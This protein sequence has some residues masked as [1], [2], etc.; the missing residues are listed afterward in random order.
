MDHATRSVTIGPGYDDPIVIGR[1]VIRWRWA[2]EFRNRH[3]ALN[4][5]RTLF[6][7]W[8]A[9]S[10]QCRRGLT[11]ESA[12]IRSARERVPYNPVGVQIIEHRWRVLTT[13]PNKRHGWTPD[14]QSLEVG[15]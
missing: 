5:G 3:F 14:G 12:A 2:I 6:L 13:M 9:T 8:I 11:E 10:A 4:E 1:F 15:A 7:G